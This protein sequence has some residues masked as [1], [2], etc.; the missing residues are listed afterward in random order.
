P[1]EC[2]FHRRDLRQG[3]RPGP[4][5]APVFTSFLVVLEATMRGADAL[6]RQIAVGLGGYQRISTLPSHGR[7]E[8]VPPFS[9]CGVGRQAHEGLLD[10]E[11]GPHSCLEPKPSVGGWRRRQGEAS[12]CPRGYRRR[13]GRA[14]SLTSC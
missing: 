8:N 12:P 3:C 6:P 1:L 10:K 4:G 5:G 9:C 13:S 7:A 14:R 11:T 2:S